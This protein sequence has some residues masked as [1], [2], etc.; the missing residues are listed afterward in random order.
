MKLKELLETLDR[1]QIFAIGMRNNFV[2][3]GTLDEWD[4]LGSY[5]NCEFEIRLVNNEERKKYVPLM[6]REVR[7]HFITNVYKVHAIRLE[8]DECGRYW[9]KHEFDKDYD[10]VKKQLKEDEEINKLFNEI[11]IG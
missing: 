11:C 1:K 4:I 6:E 10:P 8:G 5:I 3:I 2:F 9:F 7:T